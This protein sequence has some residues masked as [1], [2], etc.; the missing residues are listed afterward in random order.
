[1]KCKFVYGSKRHSALDNLLIIQNVIKGY[2]YM[3]ISLIRKFPYS[4][5][6]IVMDYPENGA[7]T[8]QYFPKNAAIR[9]FT[10]YN[11]MESGV[12]QGINIYAVPNEGKL[13]ITR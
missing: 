8:A 1:M 2:N 3:C 12:E 6:A 4:T 7:W 9:K 10:I 5:F 13:S 11:K